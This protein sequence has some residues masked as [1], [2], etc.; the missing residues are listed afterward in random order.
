[1]SFTVRTSTYRLGAY[2][3]LQALLALASILLL[4]QKPPEPPSRY[5]L[6]KARLAEAHVER[7]VGLP[8]RLPSS[9]TLN[10]PPIYSLSFE[11]SPSDAQQAWSVFLPR[12]TNG[13]EV[14]VNGAVVLDS[15][16]NPA[17]NRPD[18]N[19]P[20]IAV[21]PAPLLRDGDNALTIRLFVHGPLTGFLDFVY[22]GPDKALRPAFDQRTLLFLTFPVIF[23][24]WQAIL[25]AIL[26]LMWLKRRHKPA[27]GVLAA[28]MT[29]GTAQALVS[30]PAERSFHAGLN[31][32]LLASA[33]LE[34]ALVLVFV[35]LVIGLKLPRYAWAI[36]VP[37]L[38]IV[39]IGLF[40]EPPMVRRAYLFL[41]SP[42]VGLCL[43]IMWVIVGHTAVKRRDMASLLL[44]SAIT[45]VLTCWFHDMLSVMSIITDR[46]IF[47]AR[48]SYSALLIAIGAGLTWRF[49]L[50][51]NEVDS[52]AGRMVV[53]VREAEDKLRASLAAEEKLTHATALAAERTR[54][55]RDLHDGLGG[56]LVSIVALS[57]RHGRHGDRIGEAARGA[58]KDLRL[59]IDAM[60]DI[61]GDLMLA[62]GSWRERTEAQLRPHGIG[63]EWRALTPEGLPVHP[64]LRPWHV[65]QILRLLDETVTNAV[66]H[67]GARMITVRL[68]T[69]DRDNGTGFGRITIEDDG[70]GFV[71]AL[72]GTTAVAAPKSARGLTNMRRRAVSC[73]ARLEL[74]SG[75]AGTR[76]RLDL[77]TRFPSVEGATA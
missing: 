20:E 9:S 28:A 24:A 27:H 29:L 67:A 38:L 64:E 43:I 25:A 31:A 2:L 6:T 39:L 32:I 70:H 4:Q 23:S 33:P 16:R 66:K 17:A 42:T 61:D 65:I 12:F 45:F 35:V 55:M 8:S 19:T 74:A 71:L 26:G 30:A 51:L 36:F 18:R 60:D 62:L 63:L 7:S 77:P 69:I 11:R 41:G 44:G 56:Q 59:V 72:D 40:G 52:F 68:E 10:D 73:G 76:V 75:P 50:A 15:R 13:V 1:V 5:R 57:E 3:L 53:L 34:S 58:L 47:F 22:V 49:A 54:L 37:S 46:R 14:A 21:I 48:M